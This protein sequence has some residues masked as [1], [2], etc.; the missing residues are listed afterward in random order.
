[1][2]TGS[3]QIETSKACAGEAI[4]IPSPCAPQ[5]TV[6]VVI[7]TRNRAEPLYE[8]LESLN[9]QTALPVKTVIVDS[10]PGPETGE[11]I[12]KIRSEL[13]YEC[14]YSRSPVASAARQRNIGS[15]L[16]STDLILFLDDDVVLEPEF[17]SGLLVAF[18]SDPDGTVAGVSGTITNSVYS[19]PKGL[20]RLLLGLCL[21]QF[22]GSF[23][24]K[25]LGPAVN[26]AP[27]DE[28]G[29]IQKVGWLPSGCTAYRR[30]VFLA[31]QFGSTFEGYS[32]AEDVHLSTRIARNY[33]LLNTTSARLF[34]ADLGKDTHRDWAALGKSQVINRHLI[35]TEVLRKKALADN[36]RLFLYEMV[37]TPI[38]ILASL[39]GRTRWKQVLKLIKGKMHGF[40]EVWSGRDSKSPQL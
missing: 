5:L 18:S 24:G 25:V 31:Y 7:A 4:Q 20:N 28:P 36:L 27:V 40:V 2:N 35:M 22:G 6:G 14:E 17:I 32:F 33:Q 13:R 29:I 21:G 1:M 10:S 15:T 9:G 12:R 34:H 39:E 3:G 30:E 23:A 11:L 26:F 37:Y 16:V 19:E 38:A 8:C